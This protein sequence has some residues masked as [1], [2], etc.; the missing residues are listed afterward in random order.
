MVRFW[1]LLL[2]ACLSHR[3][4]AQ[5]T[6]V[7]PPNFSAISLNQFA[8]HELEVPYYL[9]HFAQVANAVVETGTNRGFLDIK[10]NREPVDN[11]PYNARIMEMQE[12]LAY[13]YAANRPWNFYYGNYAVRVRLEAMLD[14]WTRIQNQPGS[15]DGDYDGLF[16]EYSW[17]NWSLAPTGFGV[18]AAAETLH[19]I[20]SSGLPFDATVLEAGRVSLRRALLA[21]FT[22][23]DMRNA[24]KQYSNQ[25]SG[26][27]H[28]AL[29]YLQYWPDAELDTA[30]VAA[31]NAS[32]AQDQSHAGFWYEQGG[33]DFGY[34]SVHETSMR[35]ALPRLRNR[36]DL[37]PTFIAA[38][39]DW[40]NWM[41]ANY[42]PQPGTATRTFLVNGGVNTRT[43][44][45]FINPSSRPWGEFVPLSRAFAYTD[46]EYAG[47]LISRRSQAQAQFGL[48]GALNTNSSSSYI[49]AFVHDAITNLNNWHPTAS[50]RAAAE[51]TLACFSPGTFNRL[52]RDPLP[53]SFVSAKRP[54][55]FAAVNG[56]NIRI[57]RQVYG[58]G[59]LWNPVFGIALQPVANTLTGNTWV[60]GTKQ[61]G[62]TSTYET[63][64]FT[65]TF[66][67]GGVTVAP[68]NG[69]N[70]LPAG[71]VMMSYNLTTGGTSY[72]QK[73]ITLDDTQVT[74]TLTHSGDF[75]ELLPLAHASDV[76]VTS[77]VNRVDFRRPNGSFLTLEVLT[78]G[79]SITVGGTSSL[80]TGI[81][82]RPVTLSA[83]GSLTY[84]LRL[85]DGLPTIAATPDVV[86]TGG[87]TPR[88]IDVLANDSGASGTLTLAS[89]TSPTNG[90][91]LITNQLIWYV[92][93]PDF[94]GTDGFNY[95]ITNGSL[96]ATGQVSIAVG[97]PTLAVSVAQV[98]ASTDDGNI[99]AN[100]LDN[101]YG[102][103]WSALGDP[104]WLQYDLQSTQKVDAVSAAFYVG[105]T[106]FNYFKLLTSL[107]GVNWITNFTGQSSGATTNL[108]RF[109]LPETWARYV[110]Y[111]GHS[112]SQS[113]WNSLTE[114]RIHAAT[115]AAPLALA[116]SAGTVA[117][118]AVD[119]NPLAN[120]SD[121]DVGPQPLALVSVGTPASG[122]ISTVSGAVRYQPNAGFSGMDTL[123]YIISD[124]GR[125]ATGSVTITVSNVVNQP[126]VLGSLSGQSVIGGAWLTTTN[127]ASDPDVPAQRLLFSLLSAPGTATINP[128]T[129]LI[130]W[131]PTV[132]E[133]GTSNLFTVVVTEDGWQTNL[134]AVADAYVRDGSFTNSNFGSSNTLAARLSSVGNTYE[135][136]L[137][138]N[139][140]VL[141]GV[142]REARLVLTPTVV[143][144]P[145]THAVAYVT[146]DTWS[147]SVITWSNRP[148]SGAALATWLPVLGQST[149]T[150]VS[151]A[152]QKTITGD[153]LLSV[154]VYAA[155]EGAVGTVNYPAR[156]S[157]ATN[158]PWL[159][160][161][162][163]NLTSK[164]ATNSIWVTVNA[165]AQPLIQSAGWNGGQFQLIITG[166][167]GPDYLV[168]GTTNLAAAWRTLFTTNSPPLP[169]QWTDTNI[170]PQK[171][172]RV[173][174][175]P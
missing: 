117:G 29:I 154:R 166:D 39:A 144:F 8:D 9:Y 20:V 133:S 27:H 121:S 6:N 11:Q 67:V 22:R 134:P 36:V 146:N 40:N 152:A 38:D 164:S 55:Y 14:R 102:T 89:F 132:A 135:S 73:N 116:D 126:P 110:R 24:A 80:T 81:V 103:R 3:A 127:A 52:Y 63:A 158:Q 97:G 167:A 26:A 62:M 10:V 7:P 56:G 140:P 142:F 58:L 85:S 151:S 25:F 137:R 23:S 172:Y 34:T 153:G 92:P 168:Q 162:S 75:T 106:R 5:W 35:I 41:A 147:E 119:V 53:T 104:Q 108:E 161:I 131:R 165:P 49:P 120:D 95:I 47:Y 66:T 48:W 43:T 78:P 128:A 76:V 155:T 69:S 100:T 74:V 61:S 88:L 21:L 124:S 31:V 79:A 33:P 148:S 82:R 37:M 138:F 94:T 54:Q 175:G 77:A 107:D 122:I 19:L 64:S 46:G 93:A 112:N 16:G 159:A 157:G 65:P 96:F 59:L 98:S 17:N 28:A 145:G 68:T 125:T 160:V 105:N 169:F 84:R 115:N 90:T 87:A 86:A 57:T 18:R 30:Y 156:E 50:Q 72:G 99:P 139:L 71:D 70:E 13:F 12:A 129:G 4:I 1:C 123:N 150:D 174:L 91:A 118:V 109:N 141:P 15:A 163:T 51:A 111:L 136:Y 44:L 32:C 143:S 45:S 173:L 60:Y 130:A 149:W 83:N 101:N 170:W 114:V 42:V 113:G 171:F 2:A